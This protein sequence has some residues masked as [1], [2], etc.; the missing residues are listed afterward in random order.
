MGNSRQI[1]AASRALCPRAGL[2]IG[3]LAP[4]HVISALLLERNAFDDAQDQGGKPVTL[5]RKRRG[6][7]FNRA[8]I[9]ILEAAA[10]GI[11]KH[12]FSKAPHKLRSFFF[13]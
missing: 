2:S 13:H 12:L 5:P 8:P 4:V 7:A 9:V 1:R 3:V 10:Q 11:G 6:D